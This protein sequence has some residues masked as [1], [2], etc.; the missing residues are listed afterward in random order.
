MQFSLYSSLYKPVPGS[1]INSID[2]VKALL[3][4]CFSITGNHKEGGEGLSRGARCGPR[5]KPW[6]G[7]L[8][9]LKDL[10]RA[11]LH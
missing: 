9:I 5:A 8:D 4:L 11:L 2:S 1:E 10:K 6:L 7:L 3:L